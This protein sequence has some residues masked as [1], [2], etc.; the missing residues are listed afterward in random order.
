MLCTIH[1]VRPFLWL[2]LR[3]AVLIL[4]SPLC[5]EDSVAFKT[6][7]PGKGFVEIGGNWHF[8][9]GDDIAWVRPTG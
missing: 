2:P 7:D 6:Q 1:N 4:V 9:T 5:G 3:L 8:H